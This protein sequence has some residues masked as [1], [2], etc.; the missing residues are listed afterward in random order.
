[1]SKGTLAR[2]V[3]WRLAAILGPDG[4]MPLLDDGYPVSHELLDALRPGPDPFA[5]DHPLLILPGTS[6]CE[7][8]PA[9]HCRGVSGLT[10]R[11]RSSG[12]TCEAAHD[13]YRWRCGSPRH[14][15]RWSLAGDGL[16][17]DDL[18]TGR[19]R[20]ELVLR[21]H[22]SAG[23]SAKVT[24]GTALVTSVAGAFLMTVEATSPVVLA[25]EARP[26][27][28][29]FVGTVDAPVLTCRMNAD[30][31]ARATTRWSH[32]RGDRAGETI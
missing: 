29:R 7:P 9:R 25:V 11:V 3:R 8:G 20:H 24:N 14:R 1:V 28:T 32:A 18:V 13:G 27:V 15:Q 19:G 30:L 31:P 23:A 4:Q 5:P 21:W 6:T 2:E 17:I 16:R 22:L 26:V 10:A 12:I